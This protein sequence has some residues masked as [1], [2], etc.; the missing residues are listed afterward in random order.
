MPTL[1]LQ[2]GISVYIS[3]RNDWL[4]NWDWIQIQ[5]VEM[6]ALKIPEQPFIL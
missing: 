5:L 2:I 6:S 3:L 4:T 1:K